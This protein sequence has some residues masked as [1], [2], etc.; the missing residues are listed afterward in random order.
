MKANIAN[1]IVYIE[2]GCYPLTAAIYKRQ[3][4]FWDK[5]MNEVANDPASPIVAVYKNAID[6]KLPFIMHYVN[7]HQKFNSADECFDYYIKKDRENIRQGISSKADQIGP[8][9]TYLQI[10]PNL[11]T[12]DYYSSYQLCETDR[13]ILTKYRSGSHYLNVQKGRCLNTSQDVKSCQCG[14]REQTLHHVIFSCNIT[15]GLGQHNHQT[16]N[17]FFDDVVGAPHVLRMVEHLLKLR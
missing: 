5:I 12:P 7:L 2:S 16:L 6:I 17:E 9:A 8:R 13:L 15:A 3:Y 4:N 10:N 1:E 11:V 14:H